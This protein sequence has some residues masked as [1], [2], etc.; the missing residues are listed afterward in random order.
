MTINFPG[1]LMS[2]TQHNFSHE[3]L[4]NISFPSN[5]RRCLC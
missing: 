3:L 4:Y 2:V 1:H 5:W